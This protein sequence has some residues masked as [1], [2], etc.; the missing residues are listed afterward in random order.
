MNYSRTYQAG[1]L[2][3]IKKWKPGSLTPK[4]ESANHKARESKNDLTTGKEFE[5]FQIGNAPWAK[6]NIESSLADFMELYK[7]RPI[8]NNEGG[9]SSVG[10]FSLWTIL[11]QIHP[12]QVIQCGVFNGQTTWLIEKILPGANILAIDPCPDQ[13]I[14][15]SPKVEY[16]STT[17]LNADLPTKYLEK[18]TC[19][20][21]DDHG[22]AYK[23]ISKC[24]EIGIEYVIFDDNYPEQKGNRHRSVGSILSEKKSLNG[25]WS[26]EKKD[27]LE[28]LDEYAIF[29]PLFDW[30]HPIT[31]E[32]SVIKNPSLLGKFDILDKKIYLELYQ[33]MQG[34]RWPTYLKLK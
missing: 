1:M 2:P 13:K 8:K 29:P 7:E 19:V 23:S 16:L 5:T 9:L 17:F 22:D 33:G 25:N 30:S 31:D 10:M 4:T 24:H 11:K 34:Y 27:L 21:F 20:F 6:S 12:S 3:M 28:W 18:N 26:P 15:V 32:L 14:F